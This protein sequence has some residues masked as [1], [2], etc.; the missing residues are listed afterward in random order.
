[1]MGY[2]TF[3]SRSK[4]HALD[5]WEREAAMR[6]VELLRQIKFGSQVA[7]EEVQQL[8]NYFV[9]THQWNQIASG[10]LDII[11]GEKGAGKSAIYSLLSARSDEFFS[12]GIL[13]I[14]A[15]NPRGTTVFRDLISNPPASEEEFK[16]LWKVYLITLV[17]EKMRSQGI[18]TL[19]AKKLYSAL[20]EARLL[21][22]ELNLAGLLRAAHRFVK[23]IMHLEVQAGLELDQATLLPSAYIGKIS[24]KEPSFSMRESGFYSIDSL[25][26][27]ADKSLN[28]NKSQAWLL[29]DRLD[30]AFAENH[31]LEANALRALFR[32]YNDIGGLQNI[33]LKIFLRE[34]IWKENIRNRLSGGESYK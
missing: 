33:S 18:A 16:W 15:E 2:S 19:E 27:L 7:E 31:Q 10:E 22:A 3:R 30:V 29:L 11:R 32:V 26:K 28:E 1:M 8:Q 24:F 21:G 23:H 14:A 13:L 17:A 20:E 9:E 25:F 12:Q 4:V 6:Q 5:V 34:D